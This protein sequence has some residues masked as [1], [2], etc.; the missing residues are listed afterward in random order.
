M[1][2]CEGNQLSPSQT[3]CNL[4]LLFH[5]ISIMFRSS[6]VQQTLINY[7]PPSHSSLYTPISFPYFM[8]HPCE[9]SINVDWFNL[10]HCFGSVWCSGQKRQHVVLS[11][12]PKPAQ[13]GLL[14]HLPSFIQGLSSIGLGG[15]CY[16]TFYNTQ[17]KQ[18]DTIVHTFITLGQI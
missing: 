12:A 18:W 3:Q 16:S 6:T 8:D 9:T 5:I 7:H 1:D 10:V 2:C 15:S 13:S 11:C 4:H 17:I 14:L